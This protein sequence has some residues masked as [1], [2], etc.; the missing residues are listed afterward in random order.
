MS[1]KSVFMQDVYMLKAIQRLHECT[2]LHPVTDVHTEHTSFSCFMGEFVN[3]CVEHEKTT[4]TF[5]CKHTLLHTL[6]Q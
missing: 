2:Q 1:S 6:W 4:N 3:H 5:Y